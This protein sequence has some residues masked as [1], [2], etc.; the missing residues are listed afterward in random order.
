MDQ[1]WSILLGFTTLLGFGLAIWQTVRFEQLNRRQRDFDWPRFRNAAAD[2]GRAVR[3]SGFAPDYLVA[4]S[5]RGAIVSNLVM[6]ELRRRVPII[7]LGYLFRPDEKVVDIPGFVTLRL[8]KNTA[9]LPEKI[10]ELR[11]H[12]V[13][14]VDDLAM[15]GEALATVKRALES[16]GFAPDKIKSATIVVTKVANAGN[17]GPDFFAHEVS[18]TDFNFPWGPAE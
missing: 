8:S 6:L 14:I 17:K 10:G 18:D 11:D 15:S 2:L 5:E 7:T 16:Q 4:M 12:H 9:F 13:L 3:R 1:T